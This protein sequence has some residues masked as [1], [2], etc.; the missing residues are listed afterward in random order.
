MSRVYADA[1]AIRG[2]SWYEYDKIRVEWSSPDRYEIVRRLGGGRYSQVFEGVDTVNNER[3]VIKVLKPVAGYKIK[4]E[5]KILRNLAGAPN[6]IALL[7]VVRD[8][9]QL[10]HSLITEYVEAAPWN[11]LYT[12]LA[13]ADIRHYTF[14]LLT[15]LDFIHAHG[16]IH[17]DIKP[18]NVM[19]DHQRRELRIIDWGLAEFYHPSVK[20]HVSVGSRPYKAPELLVGYKLYDYS[21]DMWSTGCMFAA[22]IF[23]KQ[24]FFR[25]VDNEDQLLQIVRLLGSE[26]FDAY[27]DAYRIRYKSRSGYLRG[28]PARPWTRF[29][30]PDNAH[31]ASPDALD[32]VDRLLRFD[33]AERLTAAEAMAHA[34][35][36]T[37]RIDGEG[38]ETEA[39]I[40]SGF[41]SMSGDDAQPASRGTNG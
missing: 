30:A 24:H 19:I 41:A 27:L 16:I 8:P 35:F 5:V 21:L 20:Y 12:S 14:Q 32:F 11:Q 1:N 17:R 36:G 25:G 7:D 33:P 26:R 6:C 9:S 28:Y 10:Y 31:L 3:C 39:L 4:R 23:R 37:V 22:M 34:Y 38:S 2:E 40:D 18:A 29:V 13:E 15:A